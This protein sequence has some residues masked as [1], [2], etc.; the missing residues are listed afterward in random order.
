MRTFKVSS[1]SRLEVHNKVLVAVVAMQYTASPG[2]VFLI[3]GSLNLL[4]TFTHFACHPLLAS[5]S[6]NLFLCI[7]SGLFQITQ[8][9][10]Y[11]ICLSLSNL[12]HLASC[13]QGPSVLL[14]MTVFPSF[15]GGKI[16]HCLYI[17]HFLY[18]VVCLWTLT[19]FPVSWLL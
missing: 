12:L 9:R 19:L 1:Y 4:T 15:Y 2:C 6:H 3:I 18:P 8:I 10:S 13:S 14:Q 7:Y 16:F 5:S 17:L 11:S